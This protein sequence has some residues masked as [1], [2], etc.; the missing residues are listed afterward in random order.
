MF[1]GTPIVLLA[2]L[3]TVSAD[4]HHIDLHRRQAVPPTT[5]NVTSANVTTPSITPVNT[6]L[7]GANTTVYGFDVAG[8][9]V[10]QYLGIPFGQPANGSRRFQPPQPIDYATTYPDG[11]NA[12]AQGPACPQQVTAQYGNISEDCLSV[13]VFTP[14]ARALANLRTAATSFGSAAANLTAEYD[15]GLPV[16]VWIYGGGFN[17][18]STVPY[19]G[20]P[21]V[22]QSLNTYSPVVLVTLN[23]RVGMLGF[24][25]G[26]QC[27][28]EGAS[29][30]GLQDQILAL[31]WVQ[32]YISAFG[33]DPNKVT[34]FGESAGGISIGLHL[35]NQAIVNATNAYAFGNG[36]AATAGVDRANASTSYPY[37]AAGYGNATNSSASSTAVNVT[38]PLFRA[39]IL[40]SGSPSSYP[41]SQANES[42]QDV[43]DYISQGVG[44]AGGNATVSGSSL[45][46]LRNASV[47]A[48]LNATRA[49][50]EANP[51]AIPFG[52]SIDDI[53]IQGSPTEYLRAGKYAAVP[54]ITGDV[55]DEGTIFVPENAAG[56]N[57][58]S[59]FIDVVLAPLGIAPNDTVTSTIQAYYTSSA[60][61]PFDAPANETF[62][63]APAYRQLAAAFGDFV[64]Q[65]P[66]RDLLQIVDA[67]NVSQI[68]SYLFSQNDNT[69]SP[70]G[71][72]HGSDV[73]YT[74]GAPLAQPSTY[75][76]A[77][78]QLSS[79]MI[80]YFLNF[81]THLSPNGESG[82]LV[83]TL[84]NQALNLTT[85]P[86]YPSGDGANLIQFEASNLTII[87]DTYRREAI[88]YLNSI[89]EALGH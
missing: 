58:I 57:V 76:T 43:F 70:L 81:A 54:F 79:Q 89:P 73:P 42:R 50:A 1:F 85:W 82:S 86:A 71:V 33:G 39:A 68:W 84:V 87:Q 17:A 6:T 30:L 78:V 63:L 5:S 46:C 28:A 34:V 51:Y 10:T 65:A 11:I 12:T 36:S 38:G 20:I 3:A 69:S 45:G 16:L 29:N 7:Y 2:A 67:Q 77:R 74:F 61:S 25:P 19:S 37:F 9:N 48:L 18:G 8:V 49:Y 15:N 27:A 40:Q 80:G 22:T 14:S 60:G 44:C 26:A 72:S 23:Y 59:N 41:L 83:S 31:Q 32:Q 52:P 88:G 35:V 75:G 21:I 53:V 66:R 56:T 62:G 55:L 13:N 4:L 47:T 64:F 24:C